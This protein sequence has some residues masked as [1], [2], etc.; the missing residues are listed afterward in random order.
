VLYN[1]LSEVKRLLGIDPLDTQEDTLL[2]LYIGTATEVIETYLNRPKL[3]KQ[4]RTEY[5]NGSGTQRLCLRHRP[6]YSTPT[7]TVAYSQDSLGGSDTDAFAQSVPIVYGTDFYLEIDDFELGTSSNGILRYARGLWNKPYARTTGYLA[8]FVTRDTGSY[9]ITYT[10]GYTVDTLPA[11]FRQACA[12]LVSRMRYVFPLGLELTSENY[13]D[14]S[15]SIQASDKD[16]MLSLV[17][18]LL[19]TYRNW[20]FN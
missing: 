8:P 14:R 3:T 12:L 11:A 17:K 7:I 4:A 9:R 5:V 6:V 10:G 18:P 19:H 20:R 16:Y 13:E 15:I 2:W 1:D